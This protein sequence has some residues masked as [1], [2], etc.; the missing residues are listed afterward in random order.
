M[1]FR[2]VHLDFHTSEKIENIGE[3]F[4]KEGFQAALKLGEVD[5]ITVFSKCHHGWAYHPSQAN[6]IHPNLKF[7]LLGAQ[8]EAAHEIGVNTPVYLSAGLDEKMARRHP[9]WLIRGKDERITWASDF[10]E[11]GYHKFCFSSPYL[12]YLLEQIKEVCR[13]YDADGIFLDIVGVSPCCCQNCVSTMLSEGKDPYDDQNILELAEKVYANYTSK[14]REAIDSVKKGLPVF[15]NG[16]HIVKGRR[17]LAKMNTHLELESLPTGG[18]GYDHFPLSAAYVRTLGMDYLGMTGKFHSMWGEFGGFKHPNAIRYETALNVAFGSKCS[19]GDQLHPSGEMDTATYKLLGEGYS[20]VAKCEEYLDNVTPVCDVAFLS[21]EIM[22]TESINE[23]PLAR[24]GSSDV[25][26]ARILL[27]G[28]Y[29]FNVIDSEED[30]GKYKV[31]ILP[32]RI[33]CGEELANKLGAFVKGGG[34]LLATGKS[35]IKDG[36]F[37]FDFGAEY[38]SENG[39]K[40]DYI[41]PMFSLDCLSDA[42]FI[43]YSQGQKISLNEGTELAKRENPY[44]NRTTFEFC[45]HQHSPSSGEYGGPGMVSGSD[46][47]YIAWEIFSDY[48]NIGSLI[49]KKVVCHALDLLL[50]DDK[51]ITTNLPAQGIIT[52]MEQKGRLVNHIL[53]GSPV[54]R[55]DNVPILGGRVLE[56]MEDLLPIIETSVSIKTQKPVKKVMLIPEN[57]EIAFENKDGRVSF[58]IDKF[59]CHRVVA[60]EF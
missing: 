15:H 44:F 21:N 33:I 51:T 5:S 43:M 45:S 60:L 9:E 31:I 55:G 12:D 58:V 46:G 49:A 56:V 3:K 4:T 1:R 11:P 18:W 23:D 26:C 50:A 19:V 34:K 27:E 14:V 22:T 24:S 54:K 37:Q 38:I 28:K 25:G 32:D 16:G 39:Y 13:N 29:L 7:D 47:I 41:R 30:F 20:R 17:D 57:K 59:T 6:E 35:A 2:Q 36:K 40:P 48:A 53:Y 52:L 42:A 10:T 8:I